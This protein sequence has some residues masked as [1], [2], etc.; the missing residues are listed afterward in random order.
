MRAAIN[1]RTFGR[2]PSLLSV[3]GGFVAGTADILKGISGP[4]APTGHAKL[5]IPKNYSVAKIRKAGVCP[6]FLV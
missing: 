2:F 5:Q 3:S 4:L 1:F 6:L